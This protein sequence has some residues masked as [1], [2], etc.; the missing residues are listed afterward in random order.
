VRAK[1]NS[2][3]T[4]SRFYL[5]NLN[6]TMV[7]MVHKSQAPTPTPDVALPWWGLCDLRWRFPKMRSVHGQ[8]DR[9]PVLRLQETYRQTG[10]IRFSSYHSFGATYPL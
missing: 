2:T 9:K 10:D 7:V 5:S 1:Y 3:Q 6:G 4:P 8:P